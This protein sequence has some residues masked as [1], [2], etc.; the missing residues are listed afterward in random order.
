MSDPTPK[1][2]DNPRDFL[3]IDPGPRTGDHGD[4]G[5]PMSAARSAATVGQLAG[6]DLGEH[7]ANYDDAAAILYAL[8]VGAPAAQLDLVYERD[9]RVLP[10][11]ACALGLW[12]VEAAGRLGAYDPARSLHAAQ[13]LTMRGTLPRGGRIPMT[14]RIA[15]V[16]DKGKAA[17]VEIEVTAEQFAATYQIFLPGLGGWGGDRGPSSPRDDGVKLSHHRTFATSPELAALYRLT[18]DRHPVHI[19]PAV[20]AANGLERPILHGLCTLGIAVRLAADAVGAHPTDLRE[21]QARL[22]AP[23]LPG[24]VL[25]VASGVNGDVV[26]FEARAGETTVLKG[27]QARFGQ[28]NE[29]NDATFTKK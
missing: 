2:A 13:R 23:V 27:G 5:L 4:G 21:L 11:Y 20:A 3:G 10:T 18:G 8:A 7:T 24:D 29:I 25:D 26:H 14:G 17:L 9:L 6:L 1:R 19:D 16:Y 15:N 22:A 12:A 28:G